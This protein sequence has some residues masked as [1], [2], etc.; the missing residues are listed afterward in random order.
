ML[1]LFDLP[2]AGGKGQEIMTRWWSPNISV[3]FAGNADVERA[4]NEDV[5]SYGTQIGWLNEVVMALAAQLPADADPKAKSALEK[6][7]QADEKIT[8]I[9]R[10]R[11]GNAMTKA[12]EALDDLCKSDADGYRRLVQSLD[13]DLPRGDA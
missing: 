7:R 3:N 1:G 2:G 13:R 6:I 11:K 12:R 9:I 4:I 8:E 10:W 5:A